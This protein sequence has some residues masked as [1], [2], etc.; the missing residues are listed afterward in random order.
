MAAFVGDL[1]TGGKRLSIL[2]SRTANGTIRSST[3]PRGVRWRRSSIVQ[4]KCLRMGLNLV[5]KRQ[6]V[7]SWL[8]YRI[9]EIIKPEREATTYAAYE[10]FSQLHLK[11][12][13]GQI[14]LDRLQP[15]S[16]SATSG[17]STW[18]VTYSRSPSCWGP[19]RWPWVLLRPASL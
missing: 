13:P 18:F 19:R 8:D 15:E 5:S 2:A 3:A 1:M 16:S 14:A 12:Y 4:R 10:T 17:S 9:E 11:P 7:G 6:A